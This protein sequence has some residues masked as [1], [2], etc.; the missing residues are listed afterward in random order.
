[1]LAAMDLCCPEHFCIAVRPPGWSYLSLL[2]Q[3]RRPEASSW[4]AGSMGRHFR[5]AV[6][7]N[8][9]AF[10]RKAIFRRHCGCARQ[11]AN[12]WLQMSALF[13]QLHMPAVMSTRRNGTPGVKENTCKG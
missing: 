12:V 6:T 7:T 1:M 9:R 13:G 5:A 3:Y 4:T 2:T 10:S 11:T 8:S